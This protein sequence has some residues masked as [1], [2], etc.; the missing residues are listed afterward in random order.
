MSK[1]IPLI[2]IFKE[3]LNHILL[4]RNSIYLKEDNSYVSEGDYLMD[5]ICID[6]LNKSFP[7]IQIITEESFQGGLIDMFATQ[8]VAIVDPI[9]GTE[10]FVSGLKEWGTGVCL[11]KNGIF[12]EAIIALP[13]LH[14]YLHSDDLIPNKYASRI[15][16]IS[17]S[18]NKEDFLNLLPGLEY[19]ILGC[20]MYSMFNVIN[21][22]FVQFENPKGARSW[23]I[24]PGLNIAL[25]KGLNVFVNNKIYNG[26]FLQPSE[27]YTFRIT[28]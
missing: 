4:H 17:S 15:Y 16:G 28:S 5:K 21:G 24:L 14:E 25:R 20:C 13:E 7:S 22:S 9:D 6:F 3:N 11:Y 18:L 27:K 2:S 1:L 23:D 19:R 10:N 12:E 26:E 8:Y